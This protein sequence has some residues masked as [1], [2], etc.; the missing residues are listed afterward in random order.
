MINAG[1]SIHL[2]GIQS[3]SNYCVVFNARDASNDRR[4]RACVPVNG[5]LDNVEPGNN[6]LMQRAPFPAGVLFLHD[7]WAASDRDILVRLRS[8]PLH[9]VLIVPELLFKYSILITV[10]SVIPNFYLGTGV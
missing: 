6:R 8:N 5:S 2:R 9:R 3:W 7:E 4:K 1:L 10:S